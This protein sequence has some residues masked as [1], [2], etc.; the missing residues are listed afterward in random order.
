MMDA[1]EK[2]YATPKGLARAAITGSFL[3]GGCY[4]E[5]TD[6]DGAVVVDIDTT[7]E[8][9]FTNKWT[10]WVYRVHPHP[11]GQQVAE[12]MWEML[13]DDDVTEQ[14]VEPYGLDVDRSGW[15]CEV[16]V[17]LA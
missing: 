1:I 7:R 12:E 8:H 4:Y 17:E 14:S 11:W 6:G 16:R 2:Q 10:I 5:L 3:R 15:W 9:G 13:G